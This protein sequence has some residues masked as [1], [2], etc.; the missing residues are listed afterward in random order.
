MPGLLAPLAV[1][2]G[3]SLLSSFLAQKAEEKRRREQA[4]RD[5]MANLQ[6]KLGGTGQAT[7]AGTP[8]SPVQNTLNDPIVNDLLMRLFAGDEGSILD[9][10]LGRQEPT[11]PR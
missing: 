5:A 10:L 3:K 7:Q 2:G 9:R 6:Q 1:M 11:G 4:R 8:V